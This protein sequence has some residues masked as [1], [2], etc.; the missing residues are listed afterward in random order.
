M[1][2]LL[3]GALLLLTSLVWVGASAGPAHATC[4]GTQSHQAVGGKESSSSRLGDYADVLVNGFSSNQFRSWRSVA[5][6][7][8]I[9][10]F[11]EVGWVTDELFGQGHYPY[12]S[13]VTDGV[14]NSS[15]S[16]SANLSTGV[17]HNFKVHDQNHD[18][19]WSFA[20]DGNPMGNEYVN[21]DSGQPRT[22][23][24]RDCSTD[25]LRAHFVNLKQIGCANC[26]WSPYSDLS[27]YVNNTSDF[28]F[29]KISVTEYWVK[30]PC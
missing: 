11:A 2:N 27:Q 4:G 14:A 10:N 12:K 26:A 23:S 3:L 16:L 30:N 21:M 28:K 6:V 5:I 19:Y 25:S 13:W 29:C 7:K 24:E 20:Y 18:N 15:V 22:E 9:N 17:T 8:N 1:R